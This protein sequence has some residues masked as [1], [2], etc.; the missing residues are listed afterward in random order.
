MNKYTLV[1]SFLDRSRELIMASD[2]IAYENKDTVGDTFT[3]LLQPDIVGLKCKSE[4]IFWYDVRVG[5]KFAFALK[6]KHGKEIHVVIKNHF[7]LRKD[8]D[9]LHK[10]IVADLKKYFL[11]PLASHYLDTFFEEKW[12]TLGSLTLGPSG[13]QTPTLVLS[14][15]ELAV[16]EYHSYFVLYK[17]N[18]PNLHY[19]VGFTEWDASI[20]FTVVKT[21]IQ[22]KASAA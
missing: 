10:D 6:D 12:L 21:I 4:A 14:W 8:F 19:R 18:D 13:I 5:E 2:H 20:M 22:V 16:R 3:K 9:V 17:M 15:H 11:L 1:S 7:G